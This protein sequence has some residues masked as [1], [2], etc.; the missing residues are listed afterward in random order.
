MMIL[1]L[2]NTKKLLAVTFLSNLYFYNHIGTL[3]QQARGLTLFQVSS[4]TS[5][6]IITIF[7]AEVPT[8]VIADRIGRKWSVVVALLLQTA[9]EWGYLFASSYMAC[10][11]IAVIAGVGFAFLSGAAEALIYDSLPQENKEDLMKKSWGLIGSAYQLAFFIAPLAGG[12]LTSNLSI[13]SYKRVILL[14]AVS[15]TVALIISLTFTE[16]NTQYHHDEKSPIKIF[17]AGFKELIGNKKLKKILLISTFTMAFPAQLI[18][19]YQPYFSQHKVSTFWIGA[20]LSLGGLLAAMLQSQ[21]YRFDKMVGKN[22]SLFLLCVLPGVF[23]IAF[24]FLNSKPLLIIFFILIYGLSDAKA[25]LLSSYKN[26]LIDD[27][28]RAT[29]LSL[30]NMISSLYIALMGL[31]IG[32]I[33]NK[34]LNLVFLFIGIAVIF[35]TVVLRVQRLPDVVDG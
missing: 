2:S 15:V 29:V 6:I 3:Y 7:L 17:Q 18:A 13:D 11:M 14:T 25:P 10:V 12:M 28:S 23:L 9:G 16:P 24:S 1:R 21:V 8:G 22:R 4:I 32:L 33:A 20:A 27:R 26:K 35:L 31:V 34:S 5:V 30:I 19:F